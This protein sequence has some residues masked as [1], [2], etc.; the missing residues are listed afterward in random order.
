[1]ALTDAGRA[2][3]KRAEVIFQLGKGIPDEVRESA[4]GKVARLAVGVSDGISKLAAHARLEPVSST[5][6]L[7]LICDEGEVEQLLSELALHHLDL[8]LA[9][10]AA[11]RN[12]TLR[13]TREQLVDSPVEWYGRPRLVG[14]RCSPCLP[15][16]GWESS[17]SA[18]LVQTASA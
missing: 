17:R 2:A 18:G 15:R 5:P 6:N 7:R 1:M 12:S 14:K 11:P 8:V 10:E 4:S 13:L 9:G 16:G 3:Y